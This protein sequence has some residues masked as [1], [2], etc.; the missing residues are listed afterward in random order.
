MKKKIIN[1]I[2][3]LITLGVCAFLIWYSIKD[4]TT[5]Q[6]EKI[7]FALGKAHYILLIPIFIMGIISHWSRAMRWKILM[8]PLDMKPKSLNVFFAVMIGYM[9]NLLLPRVGE[10]V[11]CTILARYEK[12]P[13]DKLVGTIITERAFDFLCLLLILVVAILV[14]YDLA[15]N[16]MNSFFNKVNDESSSSSYTSWYV[17]IGIILLI[18]GIYLSRN[19]LTKFSFVQRIKKALVNILSGIMSFKS[20]KNKK[21]FVFHTCLIWGMYMS[22]IVLGFHSID[23]TSHLSINTSLS[24]LSFG[25]FGMIATPG[26]IGAYT[27]LVDEIVQLYG[28]EKAISV[29]ISWIIWL[30]P[31]LIILLFGIISLII[32][33]IYNNKYAKQTG[34]DTAENI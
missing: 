32:L 5:E 17:L 4:L 30:V 25:S 16:Y 8:E 3:Y 20:M 9:T 31:T 14:Q 2:I 1:A 26:G 7:K 34:T 12:T 29:A 28:V 23:E 13:A 6:V 21:G 19:W 33:P 11:K 18:V 15:M 10:V 27:F 24:V 22:M